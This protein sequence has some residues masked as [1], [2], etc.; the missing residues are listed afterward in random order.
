MILIKTKNLLRI[1]I[2]LSICFFNCKLVIGQTIQFKGRIVFQDSDIE[3]VSNATIIAYRI[4]NKD[5]IISSYTQSNINGYFEI[6][7]E[8]PKKAIL[9]ISRLGIENTFAA[10]NTD[11]ELQIIKVKPKDFILQ[12]VVIKSDR[13][14]QIKSDTTY[15]RLK[16]FIEGNE[17]NIEDVLKKMPGIR[18]LDNGTI[19]FNGKSISKIL[20]EGEDFFSKDYQ[21]LSK[22]IRPDIVNSIEAIENYNDNKLMRGIKKSDQI[23]LNLNLSENIKTSL[24]GNISAGGGISNRFILGNNLFS[25]SKKLKAGYIGN[26][27]NISKNSITNDNQDFKK[28][29]EDLDRNL[30]KSLGDNQDLPIEFGQ[31]FIPNINKNRYIDSQSLFQGLQMN[32]NFSP[33]IKLNSYT[34]YNKNKFIN[35]FEN[36]SILIGNDNTLFIDENYRIKNNIDKIYY[37][38]ILSIEPDNKSLILFRNELSSILPQ[39]QSTLDINNSSTNFEQITI[40]NNDAYYSSE[41]DFSYT[42]KISQNSLIQVSVNYN[43]KDWKQNLTLK[44]ERYQEIFETNSLSQIAK[45]GQSTFYIASNYIKQFNKH[46]IEFSFNY[47]NK[48]SIFF[49]TVLDSP[50]ILNTN[51]II[52]NQNNFRFG[53]KNLFDISPNLNLR[54]QLSAM[55]SI[56]K[57]ENSTYDTAKF[58]LLEPSFSINFNNRKGKRLNF[59][60]DL[61]NE[62]SDIDDIYEN[63]II[64]DY[65][66]IVNKIDEINVSRN[67]NTSFRYSYLNRYSYS[68][69]TIGSNYNYIS[70]PYAFQFDVD[71]T[72]NLLNY[73]PSKKGINRISSYFDLNKLFYKVKSR[74]GIKGLYNYSEI[75]R[76]L[77]D[78]VEITLANS[79][80]GGGLYLYSAMKGNVNFKFEFNYQKLMVL[81][82]QISNRF[83]TENS[84]LKFSVISK[85]FKNFN[86]TISYERIS[87]P[88]LNTDFIDLFISYNPTKYPQFSSRLIFKNILNARSL[89]FD[90]FSNSYISSSQYN[91]VPRI[92][93]VELTWNIGRINKNK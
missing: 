93:L 73:R 15:Y 31:V 57:N 26:I 1:I 85:H 75:Q 72:F 29:Q 11:I 81:K 4:L 43:N 53:F 18:V 91:I 61:S 82:N 36:N 22:N 17:S 40:N 60:V 13:P 88:S 56:V 51:S 64:T 76:L 44:G 24:F 59:S 5:S 68:K 3:P 58:T 67:F 52:R 42:K 38:F 49:S 71:D 30:P 46:N 83:S 86:S 74:I 77:S 16:N 41:Y 37:R 66:N 33:K 79:S 48:K 84:K 20:I 34:Y 8:E 35:S 6:N 21:I 50:I 65:R 7:I 45:I 54:L 27:N 12:E 47:S 28:S 14:L 92:F 39:S 10:I 23:V 2:C 70:S 63:S 80:I 62:L 90:N 55:K 69:V 32:Y 19:T 78:Q 87:W 9:K 25:L 89:S